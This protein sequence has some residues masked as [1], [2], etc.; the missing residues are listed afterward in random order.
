M[1]DGFAV[2]QVKILNIHALIGDAK[3][4][5]TAAYVKAELTADASYKY[6]HSFSRF[7]YIFS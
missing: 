2:S 6:F 1:Q 7:P 4:I 5:Q 3:L